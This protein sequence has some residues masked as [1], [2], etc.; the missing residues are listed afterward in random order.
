MQL[1]FRH[2]GKGSVGACLL[3]L[4]RAKYRRQFYFLPILLNKLLHR[5]SYV[6]MTTL[7]ITLLRD[8]EGNCASISD[9]VALA[10]KEPQ[11][12]DVDEVFLVR[13]L[14]KGYEWNRMSRRIACY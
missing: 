9:L 10:I 12:L 11:N 1:C 5:L 7:L 4:L 8:G 6:T 3:G 2:A 14:F 13:D